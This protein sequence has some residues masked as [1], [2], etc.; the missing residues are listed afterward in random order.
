MAGISLIT[1]K[2]KQVAADVNKSNSITAADAS[3]INAVIL[4]NPY[5]LAV[6]NTSW[7]FVPTSWTMTTPPWGFPE[8]IVIMGASGVNSAKNFYGMKLGDVVTTFANPANLQ[9]APPLVWKTQ[10]RVLKAGETFEVNFEAL[11]FHDLL[12]YQFA[13]R[14]DASK[15]QLETVESA[16][17][18]L[19]TEENFGLFNVDNG[20]IRNTWY[21]AESRTLNEETKVFKY[22]FKALE[23]G[24]KLSEIL[25]I[26][27]EVMPAEAYT[28]DDIAA[29]ML[30][31]FTEAGSVSS[32]EP[33]AEKQLVL[34]Q[35]RPNPFT[36]LT[37]AGF[38][39]PEAADVVFRVFDA[40]GRLLSEVSKSCP[41]GYNEVQ[42]DMGAQQPG[43]FYYELTTPFGVR[44]KKMVL[45]D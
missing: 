32:Q 44:S 23:D 17:A 30:L 2:Y 18:L 19:L 40:S 14:F 42:I 37:S 33:A 38:I 39:L 34:L 41:A 24:V 27:E 28:E 10:D 16:E 25:S 20:E 26:D 5:A 45:I 8:K 22:R 36:D 4:G 9:Q 31:V 15:L 35:I 12:A 6:F 13:L 43:L 7:R 3:L 1:N 21:A 29:N 11:N